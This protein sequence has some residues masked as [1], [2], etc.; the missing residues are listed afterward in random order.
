MQTEWIIPLYDFAHEPDQISYIVHVPH[1]NL[2]THIRNLRIVHTMF[3]AY[4]FFI[5]SVFLFLSADPF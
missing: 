2:H 4:F 5:F 3:E 1:T